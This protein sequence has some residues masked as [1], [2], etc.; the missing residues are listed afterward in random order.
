MKIMQPQDFF[1]I[2]N[3]I[4]DNFPENCKEAADRT[5]ASRLYYAAF[6]YARKL[7][8]SW[9]CSFIQSGKTH[10][11]VA[12]G[13]KNSTVRPLIVIGKKLS[14]L[15]EIRKK[16]DYD[17]HENFEADFEKLQI[18]YE[19]VMALEKEWEQVNDTK[20]KEALDKINQR[21]SEL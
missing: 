4:K 16:A 17:I 7:L 20:Q 15:H 8:T 5:A 3:Y 1:T 14:K 18:N 2:A 12:D 11:Q 21:I 10:S 19:T 9:G 13:L 6:L